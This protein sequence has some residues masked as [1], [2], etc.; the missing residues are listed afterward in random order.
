MEK[1]ILKDALDF[2]GKHCESKYTSFIQ[3][4]YLYEKFPIDYRRATFSSMICTGEIVGSPFLVQFRSRIF[5][6]FN[7]SYWA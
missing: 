6:C 5:S 1:K 7:Q 2:S 4:Y 3:S